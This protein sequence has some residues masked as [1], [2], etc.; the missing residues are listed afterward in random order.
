VAITGASG[1]TRSINLLRWLRRTARLRVMPTG[2]HT[3]KAIAFCFAAALLLPVGAQAQ[4]YTVGSLRIE[5]PWTRATPAGARVGGGFMK[6]TN[7]G[8]EPDRLIGGS[9]AVSGRFEVH[10]MSMHDGVMR[11]RPLPDGLEIKPGQTVELKPGSFH[12]MMIDL[13]AP[14]KEGGTVKGTLVFQKAGKVD[15][16]YAVGS[17][18]GG[19]P[20]AH[21]GGAGGHRH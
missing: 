12:I 18:G 16:E 21:G 6:I 17:I 19:A 4:D 2:I 1:L 14:L 10:E 9:A 5:R 3:M 7:T 13:N 8:T 11:M 15:V 20:A